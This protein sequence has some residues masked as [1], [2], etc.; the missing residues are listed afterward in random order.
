MSVY[1][2]CRCELVKFVP[3]K[4]VRYNQGMKACLI[5]EKAFTTTDLKCSCCGSRHRTGR[6]D[7]N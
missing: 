4:Q 2:K 1:C 7:K 5:C 3:L 6:R